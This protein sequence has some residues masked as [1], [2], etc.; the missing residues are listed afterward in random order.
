MLRFYAIVV[1]GSVVFF[2]IMGGLGW[3]GYQIIA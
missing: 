1:P 3:L 2:G